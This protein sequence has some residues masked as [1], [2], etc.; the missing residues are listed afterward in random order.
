[1]DPVQRTERAIPDALIGTASIFRPGVSNLKALGVHNN[2]FVFILQL[3][4]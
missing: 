3:D 1:M 4:W 2:D